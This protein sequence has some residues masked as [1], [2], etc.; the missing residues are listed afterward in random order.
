AVT[1]I[2]GKYL[3]AVVGEGNKIDIR[4]VKPGDRIGSDW[5]ISEGLKPGEKIVV[6]GTQKV[7]PGAIVNPKPFDPAAKSSAPTASKQADKG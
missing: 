5:V 4:Q 1:E 2:Q 3:I 7:R 6:E